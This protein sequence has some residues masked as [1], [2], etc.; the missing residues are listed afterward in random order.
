MTVVITPRRLAAMLSASLVGATM[1]FASPS[2]AQDT[3]KT[4]CERQAVTI[5]RSAI[6]ELTSVV[7]SEPTDDLTVLNAPWGRVA[8]VV[9]SLASEVVQSDLG[10]YWCGSAPSRGV[11]K[12]D[13]DS[14]QGSDGSNSDGTGQDSGSSGD[15]GSSPITTTTTTTTSPPNDDGSSGGSSGG[16]DSSPS[17]FSTLPPGSSLPS[18][19]QCAAMVRDAA[20]TRP[21]NATANQTRGNT[22]HPGYPR[23][24]GDF[25]GTTDEIL[26]W[27]ACKW[28]FDEDLVRAQAAKE[29]WWFMAT[30]GDATGYFTCHSSVTHL[31]PCPESLGILQ[32]RYHF[33]SQ[34][35]DSAA[36]STAYNADYTYAVLRDCFEGG[37]TWLNDVERGRDYSSGDLLGCMGRW[38]SGRWYTN[39]AVTYINEVERL[40]D[41]RVWEQAYFRNA[42]FG[43]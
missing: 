3:A 22:Y 12:D 27:V 8:Y 34:A 36:Y 42:E 10:Q 24:D 21:H 25:I 31:D 2:S 26:Q 32:V 4:Q 7:Q 29:S 6:N 43:Q 33:H 11:E 1:T 13:A 23:V 41:E 14:D 28:G 15:S 18:S 37:E 30:Q 16:N 20:E 9:L 40:R 19:S 38:F 35:F 5:E 17:Y 39:D